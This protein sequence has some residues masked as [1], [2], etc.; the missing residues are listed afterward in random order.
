MDSSIA[1]MHQAGDRQDDDDHDFD[2]GEPHHER[3]GDFDAPVNEQGDEQRAG[4]VD[5]I[6]RTG[7]VGFDPQGR[8]QQKA[9]VGQVHRGGERIVQ[10][11]HPAARKPALG[12]RERLT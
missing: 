7:D 2:D 5:H 4:N 12:F 9:Q 1:R 3:G 10:K 6:P 8:L 11:E